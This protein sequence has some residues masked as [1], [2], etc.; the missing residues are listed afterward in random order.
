[1]GGVLA[2]QG[3][4]IGTPHRGQGARV[5][6][7]LSGFGQRCLLPSALVTCCRWLF[8]HSATRYSAAQCTAMAGIYSIRTKYKLTYCEMLIVGI[9]DSMRLAN[10]IRQ[11]KKART[12]HRGPPPIRLSGHNLVLATVAMDRSGQLAEICPVM[13]CICYQRRSTASTRIAERLRQHCVDNMVSGV[14]LAQRM[15]LVF[16]IEMR[17]AL[18]G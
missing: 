10:I 18:N 9:R 11:L 2:P 6:P 14:S 17:R 1:M 3:D 13:Q 12:P 7:R 8:R 4:G 16:Q 15:I 5:G